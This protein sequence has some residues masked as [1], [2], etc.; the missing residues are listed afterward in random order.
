MPEN[1]MRNLALFLTLMTLFGITAPAQETTQHTM[2]LEHRE[3]APTFQDIIKA[4]D[5]IPGSDCTKNP[6]NH[7]MFGTPKHPLAC[8]VCK[9]GKMTKV[10]KALDMRTDAACARE[11]PPIPSTAATSKPTNTTDK[12]K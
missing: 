9:D 2:K 12:P 4:L 3:G 8:Y 6:R 5:A 10:E 1:E 11:V 7:A